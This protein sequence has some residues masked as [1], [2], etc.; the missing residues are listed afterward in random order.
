M[1]ER[2]RNVLRS[3][4]GTCA[5]AANWAFAAGGNLLRRSLSDRSICE[6][7][8]GSLMFKTAGLQCDY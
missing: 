7:R 2:A 3:L 8:P 6:R 4:Q 1:P 5:N